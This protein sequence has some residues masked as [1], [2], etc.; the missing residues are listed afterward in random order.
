MKRSCHKLQG[1]KRG[2]CRF[3][4]EKELC[5]CPQEKEVFFGGDQIFFT[6]KDLR[7]NLSFRCFVKGS[8][9]SF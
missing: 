2:L 5:L 7:N 4:E 3:C 8:V 6:E 1:L 9:L